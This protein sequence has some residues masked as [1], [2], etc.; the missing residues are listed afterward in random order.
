MLKPQ[1]VHKSQYTR[2]PFL[3]WHNYPPFVS[4]KCGRGTQFSF[5]FLWKPISENTTGRKN[6]IGV[7][8]QRSA[9]KAVTAYDDVKVTNVKA[10]V[11]VQITVASNLSNL[12]LSRGLDDVGDLLGKTLLL[13]LVAAE[14][15][16]SK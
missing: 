14:V 13:E 8:R 7:R 5:P 15:D 1:V 2:K 16:P 4:G 11:T 6:N 10:T 3:A 12:S 9:V